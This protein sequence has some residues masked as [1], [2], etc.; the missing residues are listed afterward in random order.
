MSV[1]PVSVLKP[2]RIL[3]FGQRFVHIH[4]RGRFSTPTYWVE[5]A[6]DGL[7]YRVEAIGHDQPYALIGRDILNEMT[8][9]ADGPAQTFWFKRS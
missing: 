3:V 8:L 1:I 2:L 6:L 5:I 4:G 9:V 7:L